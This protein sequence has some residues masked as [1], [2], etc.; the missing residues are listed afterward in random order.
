M[1]VL[2]IGATGATGKDLLE[3]LLKDEEIKQVDVFVRREL[4]IKHEK[5]NTHIIDFDEA[6]KWKPLVKGDTLFSC[7]GT[8]LKA[9][10]SKKAQWKVDYEYQYQFAKAAR[11]NNVPCYVLVSAE[12]ASAKSPIFYSKMKGQ[13]ED[14]VKALKFPAL[15]IFNPPLLLRERSDR[16]GEV[17]AAKLLRFFNRF[18]ILR[19]QQPLH[20]RQLAAAMLK[21]AK[22]LKNGVHSIS[23]QHIRNLNTDQST[24]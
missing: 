12:S 13:L 4:N 18:G 14:D 17:M 2:L 15:I 1:N 3:L 7:L 8:T 9:A 21:S 5:L 20:T 6:E 22:T 10:G 23:G 16:R 24:S 19:S 11:E